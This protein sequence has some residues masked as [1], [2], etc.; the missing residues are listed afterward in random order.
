[1][2][3]SCNKEEQSGEVNYLSSTVLRWLQLWKMARTRDVAYFLV[4]NLPH[5]ILF[6]FLFRPLPSG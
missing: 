2:Y 3:A 1:M 5:D 6:L 4:L